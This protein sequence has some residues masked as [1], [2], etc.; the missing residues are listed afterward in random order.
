MEKLKSIFGF[1]SF[2]KGQKEVIERLLNNESALAVFPT[3]SGKSLCFQYPATQFDNLTIVVSP[4]IALMKDQVDFLLSHNIAAARLD[5]TLSWDEVK[6]IYEGLHH[7]SI[8]ILY[9]APERLSNERFAHILEQ[10]TIDL[11]EIVN[12]NSAGLALIIEWKKLS[13]QHNTRLMLTHIPKQL[14]LLAEL[15]GLKDL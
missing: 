2:R 14:T 4:L 8:K 11:S 5:S 12:S 13:K 7:N 1:D 15:S 3:G 9:V 6:S 10:L